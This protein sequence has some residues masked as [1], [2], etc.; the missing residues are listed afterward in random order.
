VVL[1]C[2]L[3]RSCHQALLLLLLRWWRLL[4]LSCCV[5]LFF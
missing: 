5:D 4:L 3:Q 1:D 2:H